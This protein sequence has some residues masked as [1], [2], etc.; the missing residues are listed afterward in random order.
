MR[1][2]TAIETLEQIEVKEDVSDINALVIHND[3]VNTF[4]FVI[5]TLMKVC[6][7]DAL[8]AEQCTHLIHFKGKCKVKEGEFPALKPLCEAILD[9]GIQATIE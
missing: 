4:D 5:E 7:H 9:R 8:Q 1:F 2:E 3:D 6:N